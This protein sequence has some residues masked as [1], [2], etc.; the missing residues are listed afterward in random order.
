[1]DAVRD[2]VNL[3]Y[4]GKD[5]EASQVLMERGLDPVFQIEEMKRYIAEIARTKKWGR[6]PRYVAYPPIREMSWID[7][8]AIHAFRREIEDPDG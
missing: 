1:M 8:Y 5:L 3:V 4:Q 7:M 6:R 2:I